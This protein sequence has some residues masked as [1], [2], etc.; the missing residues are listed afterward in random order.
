MRV[1]VAGGTG[2]IGRRLVPQLVA[3]GHQVTA[4][5]TS[6]G[7]LGLLEQLGAE[8]IVMDGL[9]AV[10]V[11]EAVAA[12]RPDAIVN[13]MTALSVAHAG[14]PNL[15]KPDRFFAITN[16][17]RSEGTDHLLAAAE[18]TGVSHVVAQSAAIFNGIREGGWVKTEED[19]LEAVAAG[20]KAINHLED[21]V[22]GA[23]GAVLRYGGLYGAGANDDQVKFVRKGMFPLVGG[24]TGHFSW[25]HVDDAASA[26]VLAVEQKAKGVFNIVDDEPAPVSEWLPHLAEC[27]GAKP[28][29]RVPTWLARLLAGEMMVGMMTEGRGFSNAK[30][31][32]GLGW[33]PH[34]PSWRQGFE[35]EL[36]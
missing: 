3:R 20:T 36:A 26:T 15:R 12:A 7:K 4:T 8:G 30:A 23:G 19:P 17:L 18:A 11:G 25:V 34:H 14:K 5:T 29:R 6:A 27:A 32:R 16:R 31:K 10:L 2:V 1:F 35:K 24:G 28:P 13:Q 9:D 22:V 21:V 33:E